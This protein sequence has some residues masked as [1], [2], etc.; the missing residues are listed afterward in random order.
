M[1]RYI[2]RFKVVGFGLQFG[3]TGRKCFTNLASFGVAGKGAVLWFSWLV[4]ESDAIS[5]KL[6]KNCFVL[7]GA[8]KLSFYGWHALAVN[9]A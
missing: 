7:D 1:T 9:L 3:A 5:Q 4:C 8:V 6:K 2:C